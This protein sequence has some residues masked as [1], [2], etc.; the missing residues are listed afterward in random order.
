[1]SSSRGLVSSLPWGN[2]ACQ[3]C[4]FEIGSALNPPSNCVAAA[5]RSMN[6]NRFGPTSLRSIAGDLR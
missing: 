3:F 5:S 6:W 4:D 2:L 1:M